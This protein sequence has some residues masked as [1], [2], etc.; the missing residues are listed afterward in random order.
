MAVQAPP[1][2]SGKPGS[3]EP[4]GPAPLAAPVHTAPQ[5]RWGGET[6]D[7]DLFQGAPAPRE[8]WVKSGDTCAY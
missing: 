7:P 1:L 2:E 3:P 8:H 4:D 5:E 6:G